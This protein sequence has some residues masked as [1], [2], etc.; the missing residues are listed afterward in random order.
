MP[1]INFYIEHGQQRP[2]TLAVKASADV[3]TAAYI[4]KDFEQWN[5]TNSMETRIWIIQLYFN[6][7][8]TKLIIRDIT[9]YV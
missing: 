8:S 6:C 7:Y 2:C 1:S 4:I 3:V 9:D 5:N